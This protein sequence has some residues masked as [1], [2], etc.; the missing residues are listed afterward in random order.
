MN[1]NQTQRVI[2]SLLFLLALSAPLSAHAAPS[3]YEFL[4]QRNLDLREKLEALNKKY[5]E[6]ENERNVL[7]GHVRNLQ[8]EKEKLQNARGNAPASAPVPAPADE[9]RYAALETALTEV[10]DHLGSITQENV[11]VKRELAAA[12]KA[13]EESEAAVKTLEREKAALNGQMEARKAELAKQEALISSLNKEKAAR[14]NQL[15]AVE[16][17]DSKNK[18]LA[19]ELAFARA[20]ESEAAARHRALLSENDRLTK[21]SREAAKVNASLMEEKK[22]AEQKW[23]KAKHDLDALRADFSRA[24]RGRKRLEA[25]C[26]GLVRFQAKFGLEQK[27]LKTRLEQSDEELKA[28]RI[29]QKEHESLIGKLTAEKSTLEARLAKYDAP[30]AAYVRK[31]N[32]LS[33]GSKQRLDMHFNLAVAYD[34]TGMYKEEEREYL[35]CLRIDPNDANVHYNLGI[36]YDDKFND[37]LKAIK[38]YKKYLQLRPTGGDAEQVRQW[39]MYAE[40]QQRL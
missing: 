18:D 29:L 28:R 9:S 2:S 11:R 32:A 12:G 38:Y 22:G 40:Q 17:K 26:A 21:D 10:N 24:R 13:L 3:D 16:G 14:E 35:E 30:A 20:R 33:P 31:K 39:I 4:V 15:K 6:L 36:L 25:K 1:F 8:Q 23:R 7:I 34:K 5:A 37:N 19:V 27:A